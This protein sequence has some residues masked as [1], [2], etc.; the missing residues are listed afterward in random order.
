MINLI[1]KDF[2]L[3]KNLIIIMT[4]FVSIFIYIIYSSKEYN[5]IGYGFIVFLMGYLTFLMMGKYKKKKNEYMV[6]SSLPIYKNT[7]VFVNYFMMILYTLFFYIIIVLETFLLRTFGISGY[8]LTNIWVLIAPLGL[9]LINFSIMNPFDIKD[10][11]FAE[12]L[13]II[14]YVLICL[15]P[16]ILM[17]FY[18]TSM[19]MKIFKVIARPD[20][21]YIAVISIFIFGLVSYLISFMISVKIYKN[22]DN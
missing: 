22:F 12:G 2:I 1:K 15:L 3:M 18:K 4:A 6:I 10:S 16:Q 8:N 13:K 5:D 17:K 7:I 19:G 21:M 9:L 11:R 14:T 20:F